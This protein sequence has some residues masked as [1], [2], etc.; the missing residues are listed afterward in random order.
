MLILFINWRWKKLIENCS[1]IKFYPKDDRI[2]H[3]SSG[4]AVPENGGKSY[5]V[6][7]Y[8]LLVQ[9]ITIS[10]TFSTFQTMLVSN[11]CANKGKKGR[12]G[13]KKLQKFCRLFLQMKPQRKIW[14]FVSISLASFFRVSLHC[15]KFNEQDVLFWFLKA[16]IMKF[17]CM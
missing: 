11:I 16:V 2:R 5:D 9:Q 12:G 17:E 4:N 6:L 7:S 15:G 13:S 1:L 10:P 3:L 8:E 14:Y